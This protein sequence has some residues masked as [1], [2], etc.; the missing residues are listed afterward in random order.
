[1]IKAVLFDLDGTLLNR[2]LSVQKFINKQY[3][4]LK[5]ALGHIAK[6]LYTN[7]FLELDCGGYVWKDKVYQQLVEDNNISELTWGEL[8]DDYLHQF[9]NSCVPFSNLIWTLEE[10]KNNNLRLG[11]ITNG[12]GKFQMDNI[13]ALGIENYFDVILISELEGL[14][15]PDRRIFEKALKKLHVTAGESVFVGDHPINDVKAGQNVGMEG[16]WKK[17]LHWNNVEADYIIR[18]LSELIRKYPPLL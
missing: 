16:I 18:D 12:K 9:K 2:D 8:L 7:R 6:N 10:L 14:K 15:K 5:G 4:R 3:E 17:N 1:M 13:K 11:I